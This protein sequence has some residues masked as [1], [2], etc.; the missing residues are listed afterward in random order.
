[1]TDLLAAL[2]QAGRLKTLRRAGWVRKGLAAPESVADHSYRAALLAL[3]LAPELGVD[4]DRLIRLVLVH[5]LPESDP[6]VG[7]ITP[8]CGVDR[9]E[10]HRRER[11][12]MERL[13]TS[14]P[15]DVGDALRTL[16][17][18]YDEGVTPEAD[19]AHQ[20]DALE[21]ALQACEYEM[22]YEVDL[23]EF[24]ASARAKIRSPLLV[25]LLDE[26]EER[27]RSRGTA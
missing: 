20:L 3:M 19:V 16:W 12:A 8:F 4:N 2:L 17:L 21:M 13:G 26:L 7:D 22:I 27:R 10:K 18:E 9:H 15:G 25:R 14:L 24:L 5:D 11:A 6:D 1:M 23:S